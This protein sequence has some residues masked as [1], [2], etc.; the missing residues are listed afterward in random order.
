MHFSRLRQTKITFEIFLFSIFNF[1]VNVEFP[2]W[3]NHRKLGREHGAT[4]KGPYLRDR[5]KRTKTRKDAEKAFS[6][7]DMR[8]H[9]YEVHKKKPVTEPEITVLRNKG[10]QGRVPFST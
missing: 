9:D 5:T 3:R 8:R 1:S 4:L 2:V 6:H 10:T 7:E